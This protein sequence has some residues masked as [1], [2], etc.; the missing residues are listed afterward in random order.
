MTPLHL[1]LVGAAIAN[2]GLMPPV[3]LV[4]M[5]QGADGGWQQAGPHSPAVQVVDPAV[6]ERL[7]TLFQPSPD[8]QVLDYSSLAVAGEDRPAHVW[9]LGLAP[10]QDPRYVV[11]VL[12]EHAGTE[13][14]ALA[15]QIGRDALTAAL[16]LV[17]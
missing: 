4:L 5:I 17:E 14:L 10:A 16:D 3:N 12:L 9:Y 13:G 2:G 6:A 11:V 1:A 15:E 7:R 8:G